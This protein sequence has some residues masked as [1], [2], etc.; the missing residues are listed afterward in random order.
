MPVVALVGRTNVG[1]STLFNRLIEQRKALVSPAPGTTRDRNFGIVTWR[2]K[3]FTLVDTGGL[4][5]GYMPATQVPKKMRLSSR[6]HPDN[7]IETNIV[8][9]AEIAIAKADFLIMVVDG[10]SGMQTEDKTI[11]NILRK[12][13]KPYLLVV[14]KVDNKSARNE[15]WDFA[16]LGLGDPIPVSA[17]NGS[18]TGDM[19]D[20][21]VKKLKFPRA[22]KIETEKVKS[23]LNIAIIGKP[24][25]GKSSLL[26]AILGEERVIVTPIA[27][28]TRESQDAEFEYKEKV[29][30]LVDTAGIRRKSH[31]NKGLEKA[32]VNDS[33]TSIK[34]SD[35]A[36]LVIDTAAGLSVQDTRLAHEIINSR[37]GLIIVGNKWDL[38]EEKNA[39]SPTEFTKYFYGHFPALTWA[40]I[41]FISAKKGQRI[42]NALDLA[43]KIEQEREKR[44]NE[45]ELEKILT[46]AAKKH[47][48]NPVKGNIFPQIYS[49][50]QTG[51]RPPRFE[52]LVHP[53]AEIHKSWIRYLENQ[54]RQKFGFVG[55]PIIVHQKFYKK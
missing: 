7:I 44:V 43:V 26:N 45:K 5:L 12:S 34:E 48:P 28:T 51:I 3:D 38:V 20:I 9:Q 40:P 19:L 4:D 55:T 47:L 39:S 21:I 36:L 11:T 13:R 22:K 29:F 15:I 52:L 18:G 1:K 32:G 8:K 46:R 27:H 42:K 14:N 50:K 54:I 35:I 6:I 30:T 23:N 24:N 33:F 49:L 25:A 31:V 17:T 16:R 10:K 2:G 53:K 41:I 37:S